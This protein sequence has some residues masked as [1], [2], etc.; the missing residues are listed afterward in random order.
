MWLARRAGLFAVLAIINFITVAWV[1]RSLFTLTP[2]Q[3]PPP[4]AHPFGIGRETAGF[5]LEAM[6]EP[7]RHRFLLLHTFTLDL[8]LPILLLFA[9]GG[10][11]LRHADKLAGFAAMTDGWKLTLACGLPLIYA[12][13]D[14]TENFLVA[15][16]LRSS[17]IRGE[18]YL[19]GLE[20]ATVLKFVFLG[21]AM[22]VLFG[23]FLAGRI[24]PQS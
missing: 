9:L 17:D 21:L 6:N 16:L 3:I 24:R 10:A 12:V 19:V 22:I 2:L 7:L 20:A 14:L 5:W 23:A 11:T 15:G 4:D 18:L 13:C 8:T 1:D